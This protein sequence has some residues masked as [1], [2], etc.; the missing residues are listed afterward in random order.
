M[1]WSEVKEKIKKFLDEDKE[2][3][4]DVEKYSFKDSFQYRQLTI[5]VGFI[6]GIIT[7]MAIQPDLLK[8]A[9]D[10]QNMTI[11]GFATYA[12]AGYVLM[13]ACEAAGA[14]I[15]GK[16]EVIYSDVAQHAKVPKIINDSLIVIVLAGYLAFKFLYPVVFGGI[17]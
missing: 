6:V 12:F 3:H 1:K 15:L 17:R 13:I 2:S 4:K 7:V 10:F 9:M 16:A 11:L 5:A 8:S 14:F